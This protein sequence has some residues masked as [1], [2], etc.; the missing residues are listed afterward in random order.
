MC[1]PGAACALFVMGADGSRIR[2]IEF[3]TLGDYSPCVLDCAKRGIRVSHLDVNLTRPESSCLLVA[4]LPREAGGLGVP[5]AFTGTDDPDY[6]PL[7][8]AIQTGRRDLDA[9]PRVDMPG[10]KVRPYPRNFG[11]LFSGF[12]GP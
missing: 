7:L 3:S 9:N 1:Q 6:R 11:K 12:A 8:E 5:P 2:R 4:H 10:A